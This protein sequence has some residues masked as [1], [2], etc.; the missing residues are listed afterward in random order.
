M[1]IE[2][3]K[4]FQES[5]E[6]HH[7][8]YRNIGTVH[9]GLYVYVRSNDAEAF[10]GYKLAGCFNNYWRERNPECTRAMELVRGIHVGS[11]GNG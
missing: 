9:E 5:G 7:A 10:R 2:E 8:T 4:R 1:T 3:L 6:F 11:F